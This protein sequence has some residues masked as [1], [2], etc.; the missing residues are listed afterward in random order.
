MDQDVV[1]VD[2]RNEYKLFWKL[3]NEIRW[4]Q[5][6]TVVSAGAPPQTPLGELTAL[7]Q[8]P[9]AGFDGFDV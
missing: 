5:P 4:Y 3:R 7:P 8:T 6:S 1:L 2:G 9:V